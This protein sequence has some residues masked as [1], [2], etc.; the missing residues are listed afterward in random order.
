M[1]KILNEKE[2]IISNLLNK[3]PKGTE[4]TVHFKD[5]NKKI[6]GNLKSFN[7][8]CLSVAEFKE[9]GLQGRLISL[10]FIKDVTVHF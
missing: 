6:R 4:I 7:G 5:E 9:G 2:I 1:R 10:A 3:T 8:E